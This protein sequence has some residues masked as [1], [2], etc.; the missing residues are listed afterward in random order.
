[1]SEPEKGL[2]ESAP[3]PEQTAAKRARF[4]SRDNGMAARMLCFAV[5]RCAVLCCVVLCVVLLHFLF[6]GFPALSH[7]PLFSVAFPRFLS[8]PLV[9]TLLK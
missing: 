1:M 7:F 2:K 5:L 8:L 3:A 4:G 9:L 6:N